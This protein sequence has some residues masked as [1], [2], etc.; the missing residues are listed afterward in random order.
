MNI[1]FAIA[2][3]IEKSVLLTRDVIQV[4][5]DSGL[6]KPLR[7]HML[8]TR[9]ADY[10]LSSQKPNLEWLD[11]ANWLMDRALKMTPQDSNDCEAMYFTL[12]II[13][14]HKYK[15]TNLE[16]DIDKS[17][18]Y[19]R[20]AVNSL[21]EK[22]HRLPLRLTGFSESLALKFEN[23]DFGRLDDLDEALV[24]SCK[25]LALT[26]PTD[27]HLD[28]KM[29]ALCYMLQKH[30]EVTG[31][32]DTLEEAIQT[33]RS[34]DYTVP[35]GVNNLMKLRDLLIAWI[36]RTRKPEHLGIMIYI[37]R[38]LFQD[39][40]TLSQSAVLNGLTYHANNPYSN[41]PTGLYLLKNAIRHFL[42]ILKNIGEGSPQKS[43]SYLVDSTKLTNDKWRMMGDPVD[44][45][46]ADDIEVWNTCVSL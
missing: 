11:E 41:E 4:V 32:I 14:F 9:L 27:R 39:P 12:C 19:G 31:I 13:N 28:Y 6:K 43:I 45:F 25:V 26:S 3:T 5:S 35:N 23:E 34:R 7:L 17:I 44:G 18:S 8:A 15:E 21:P 46:F 22:D 38:R 42:E 30:A 20:L 16:V 10:Y 29:D 33:R 24:Y 36:E 40:I 2:A 1:R 37:G